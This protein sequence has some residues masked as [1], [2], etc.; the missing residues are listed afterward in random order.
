MDSLKVE[1]LHAF[2]IFIDDLPVVCHWL[3]WLSGHAVH[4]IL[5]VPCSD[6]AI[7]R[8]WN[9]TAPL[10]TW[11]LLHGTQAPNH[12]ASGAA[13]E[14]GLN[15][16]Y[17]VKRAILNLS[18]GDFSFSDCPNRLIQ[19]LQTLMSSH[20]TQRLLETARILPPRSQLP[21]LGSQARIGIGS[22]AAAKPFSPQLSAT[23]QFWKVRPI[24]PAKCSDSNLERPG[25]EIRADLLESPTTQLDHAPI[26]LPWPA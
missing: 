6:H 12:L 10:R 26:C 23:L 24:S 22:K 4:A 7:W 21:P 14:G 19:V 1:V 15:S 2:T 13:V 16:S 9:R 25:T 8:V 5:N 17:E 3:I 20:V 11:H 18:W